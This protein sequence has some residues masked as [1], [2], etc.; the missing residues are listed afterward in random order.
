MSGNRDSVCVNYTLFA[1]LRVWISL[2]KLSYI[3]NGSALLRMS[4]G[5]PSSDKMVDR[6]MPPRHLEPLIGMEIQLV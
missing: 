1:V 2:Q 4:D 5:N 3:R 6:Y